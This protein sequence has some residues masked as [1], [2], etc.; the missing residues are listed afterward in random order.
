M[1]F[2]LGLVL[3]MTLMFLT[4]LLSVEI[5]VEILMTSTYYFETPG[6]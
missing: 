1:I 3:P 2:E 5:V 6:K 4:R